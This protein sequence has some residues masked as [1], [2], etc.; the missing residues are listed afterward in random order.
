MKIIPIGNRVLVQIAKKSQTTKSGII[1][2]GEQ[3]DENTLGKILAIGL[4]FGEE[5]NLLEN[6]KIGDTVLFS[7]YSGQEVKDEENENY[8]FKVIEVKNISAIVEKI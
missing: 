4:G 3:K 1:I 5:K 8:T 6:F 7:S 2:S